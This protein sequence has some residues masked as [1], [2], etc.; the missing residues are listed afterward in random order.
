[1]RPEGA[2]NILHREEPNEREGLGL[3][4]FELTS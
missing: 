4:E 3:R 1:M 2:L